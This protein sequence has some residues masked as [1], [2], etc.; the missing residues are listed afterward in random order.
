MTFDGGSVRDGG[1][2]IWLAGVGE[3]VPCGAGVRR[4]AALRA[5]DRPRGGTD[6]GSA[7][8]GRYGP[9]TLAVEGQGKQG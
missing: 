8:L 7:R 2:W 6:S 5:G 4:R 3:A 1:S 9:F